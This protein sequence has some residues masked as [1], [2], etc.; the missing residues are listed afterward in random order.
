MPESVKDNNKEAVKD[1][2]SL[3][4]KLDSIESMISSIPA[5]SS[6]KNDSSY[7]DNQIDLLISE[8]S[9]KNKEIER[10]KKSNST[11]LQKQRDMEKLSNYENDLNNCISILEEKKA[12][13]KELQLVRK[14]LEAENK[15]LRERLEE[16]F[17]LEKELSILRQELE[18]SKHMYSTLNNE[19][20]IAKRNLETLEIDFERHSAIIQD[21]NTIIHNLLLTKDQKNQ[22]FSSDSNLTTGSEEKNQSSM[23]KK[24]LLI[25]DSLIKHIIPEH[26]LPQRFNFEVL[27]EKA[28]HIEEIPNVINSFDNF[29]DISTPVIHCGTNDIQSVPVDILI[30]KLKNVISLALELNP[31][32]KIIVSNLTPRGDDLMLDLTRQEFNIKIL[33]EFNDNSAI[34][35]SDNTRL[36]TDGF[37]TDKFYGQDKIHLNVDGT[38]IL[39]A[40]LGSS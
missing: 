20:L 27:V 30:N 11:L 26:L 7:E 13:I 37:I 32:I 16:N 34:M 1:A 9:S 23:R 3:I 10:L 24:I 39:A 19:L 40:N 4:A 5:S 31:N 8:I 29:T 33:K 14:E 35:I 25:G 15:R 38:K 36:S 12:E 6:T 2:S 18:T 28:Y 21:K 17:E 22:P